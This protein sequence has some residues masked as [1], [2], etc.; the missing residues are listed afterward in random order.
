MPCRT[1]RQEP[2]LRDHYYH[3]ALPKADLLIGAVIQCFSWPLQPQNPP[4]P[5]LS[6]P[7][8]Y[9]LLRSVLGKLWLE[10]TGIAIPHSVDLEG[11]IG[12]VG[13]VV[14]F[15]SKH[16]CHLLSA[17]GLTRFII[18]G[19]GVCHHRCRTAENESEGGLSCTGKADRYS[20]CSHPWPEP[21]PHEDHQ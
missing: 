5:A 15:M 12:V 7:R 6:C 18:E 9:Q 10:F 14:R 17:G 8:P 2:R 20:D 21:T 4:S 19:G 1:A 16:L 3:P 13:I 11:S